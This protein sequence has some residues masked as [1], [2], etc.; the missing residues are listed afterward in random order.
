MTPKAKLDD[1]LLDFV[2]GLKMSRWEMLKLLPKTFKGAHIH[3]ALVS[4]EQTTSLSIVAS[5]GT[6]IQA[7]G[8]II[9]R[10]ATTINYRIIPNKLR[11]IV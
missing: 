9:E 3:H 2:Y 4:Y 8:E 5:P 6:P 7:D 1:G 11:V 10:D